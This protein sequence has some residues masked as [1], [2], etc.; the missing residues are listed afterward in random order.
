MSWVY[1]IALGGLY[2]DQDRRRASGYSGHGDFRNDP[3]KCHVKHG[4]I[5]CGK[6]ALGPPYKSDKHGPYVIPLTPIEVDMTGRDGGFLVHGDSLE[7]PG[8]ASEGCII[9]P[10]NNRIELWESGCRRLLVVEKFIGRGMGDVQYADSQALQ[11]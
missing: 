4:P 11:T 10:H 2:D 8:E 6:W 5:P 7:H 9:L 1:E 3:T